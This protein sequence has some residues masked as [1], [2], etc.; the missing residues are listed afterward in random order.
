MITSTAT[1][2]GNGSVVLVTVEGPDPRELKTKSRE[3]FVTNGTGRTKLSA[4]GYAFIVAVRR[5]DDNSDGKNPKIQTLYSAFVVTSLH[6]L[7]PFSVAVA[8][9]SSSA[10]LLPGTDVHVFFDGH[11]T[12]ITEGYSAQWMGCVGSDAARKWFRQLTQGASEWLWG[13]KSP[14][15]LSHLGHRQQSD[16]EA[17]SFALLRIDNAE[18]LMHQ[19]RHA[20]LAVVDVDDLNKLSTA[21]LLKR[22]NDRLRQGETVRAVGSPFGLL[23]PSTFLNSVTTGIVSNVV[24]TTRDLILITDARMLPGTEGGAIFDETGNL[25][26]LCTLPLRRS[27][28]DVELNVG[29]CVDAIES[30]I[31]ELVE[32]NIRRLLDELQDYHISG[33]LT[34]QA[35][36]GKS[37]SMTVISSN[38]RQ[39]GSI[40]SLKSFVPFMVQEASKSVVLI[41]LGNSWASGVLI[42]HNGHILTNAHLVKPFLQ[43]QI[44][45]QQNTSP[46][47]LQEGIQIFVQFNDDLQQQQAGR[48]Y[49]ADLVFVVT[50]GTLDLALLKIDSKMGNTAQQY[51]SLATDKWRRAT[52]EI[53]RQ[54]VILDKRI[55]I[56]RGDTIYAIGFPLFYPHSGIQASVTRGTAANIVCDEHGTPVLIQTSALIHNGNSGGIIVDEQGRFLAL[57]TSNARQSSKHKLSK[58]DQSSGTYRDSRLIPSLNFAIPCAQLHPIME[59][60]LNGGSNVAILERELNDPNRASLKGVWSFEPLRSPEIIIGA[61]SPRQSEHNS[62]SLRHKPRNKKQSKFMKLLEHIN[63]GNPEHAH[64]LLGSKIEIDHGRAKDQEDVVFQSKL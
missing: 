39:W 17:T 59:F 13:W 37:P 44:H 18:H 5:G 46:P 53:E 55:A 31:S 43:P 62:S 16:L 38:A 4:S 58:A 45:E 36:L 12:S 29:I 7:S 57:V 30:E 25:I 56:R 42:S 26:A 6:V 15:H 47:M 10:A 22:R 35:A 52:T 40:D 64:H 21:P 32:S 19:N 61:S 41:H 14:S 9:P 28:S 60:L 20:H 8:V 48:I 27:D 63:H 24:G 33:L 11:G 3:F 54:P 1:Q 49:T 51:V 34:A 50:R 23:S 2:H